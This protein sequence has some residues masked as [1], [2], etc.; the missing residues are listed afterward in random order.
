MK[1]FVISALI[2]LCFGTQAFASKKVCTGLPNNAEAAGVVLYLDIQP[3]VVVV[4]SQHGDWFDGVYKT[5]DNKSAL[6]NGILEFE[7]QI[8]GYYNRISIDQN[9]LLANTKGRVK[10]YSLGEG[11]LNS[12]YSCEDSDR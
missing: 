9:L 5:T 7:G 12:Y 3:Q 6:A 11:W 1:I 2:S 4:K 10:I 8:D